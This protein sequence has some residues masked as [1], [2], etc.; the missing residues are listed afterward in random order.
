[1]NYK[2]ESSRSISGRT[3]AAAL[4]TDVVDLDGVVLQ[5]ATRVK[6]QSDKCPLENP[7]QNFQLGVFKFARRSIG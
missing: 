2:C 5:V 6:S 3:L 1:V 4:L 7:K